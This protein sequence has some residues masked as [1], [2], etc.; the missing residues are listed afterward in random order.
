MLYYSMTKALWNTDPR[1]ESKSVFKGKTEA[2]K[3]KLQTYTVITVEVMD[4]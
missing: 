2:S 4:I 3:W 1:R